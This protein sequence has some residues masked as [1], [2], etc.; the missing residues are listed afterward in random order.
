MVLS[1]LHAE[2]RFNLLLFDYHLLLGMLGMLGMVPYQPC[3]L[4]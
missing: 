1:Y 4:A 3:L 2:A